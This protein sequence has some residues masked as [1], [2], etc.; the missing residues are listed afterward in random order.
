MAMDQAVKMAYNL[1]MFLVA[2][3]FYEASDHR[4]DGNAIGEIAQDVYERFRFLRPRQ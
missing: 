2:I 1:D 4:I 3:S